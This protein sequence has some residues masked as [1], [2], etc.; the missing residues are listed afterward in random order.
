MI[1]QKLSDQRNVPSNVRMGTVGPKKEKEQGELSLYE[2][3]NS[4]I[5]LWQHQFSC[6]IYQEFALI[7]FVK[8]K[9]VDKAHKLITSHN[10][11]GKKHGFGIFDT[12]LVVWVEGSVSGA[13][14]TSV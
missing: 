10:I 12:F 4:I 9:Y 7:R 2:I 13:H 11:Y 8:P 1:S 3:L 5:Y 14:K 6:A